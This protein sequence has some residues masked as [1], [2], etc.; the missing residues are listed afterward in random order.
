M[1][2]EFRIMRIGGIDIKVGWTLLIIGTFISLSLVTGYFPILLPG[3]DT[4][5][6]LVAALLSFLGLYASV[7]LHE[8]AHAFV[9]KKQGLSVKSLVLNLFGGVSNLTEASPNSRAEF[10]R[11]VVGP[12]T[13]LGL[14]GIF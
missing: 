13:N 12:L 3:W 2:H 14:A 9:A 4:L 11:A 1:N 5:A 8:L 7:L 6:Y 10:W